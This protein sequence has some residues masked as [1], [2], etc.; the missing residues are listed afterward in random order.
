MWFL[1]YSA[2]AVGTAGQGLAEG[3]RLALTQQGSRWGDLL[4][5]ERAFFYDKW[6]FVTGDG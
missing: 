6:V 2:A 5:T 4:Q 1:L 3:L